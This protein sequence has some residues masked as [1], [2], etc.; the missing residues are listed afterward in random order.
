MPQEFSIGAGEKVLSIFF[1]ILPQAPKSIEWVIG[2]TWVMAAPSF[3]QDRPHI[4]F[5]GDRDVFDVILNEP[6]A[7][8]EVQLQPAIAST[9]LG[10]CKRAAASGPG[11]YR[12]L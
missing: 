7:V 5:M 10:A 4:I 9:K 2:E 1:E 3:T 12:D 8:P 11:F 6:E